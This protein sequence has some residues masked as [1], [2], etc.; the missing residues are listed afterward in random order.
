MAQRLAENCRDLVHQKYSITYLRE[1]AR[2][3]LTYFGYQQ[4]PS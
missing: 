1:E 3:I 4:I 2:A